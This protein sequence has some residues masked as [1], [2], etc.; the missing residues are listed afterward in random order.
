MASPFVEDP[1]ELGVQIVRGSLRKARVFRDQQNTVAFLD[2]FLYERYKF[3]SEGM[4]YLCQPLEPWALCCQCD[5]SEL[6]TYSP[7]D[8]THC[9]ALLCY[10][11]YFCKGLGQTPLSNPSIKGQPSLL[12]RAS[13][14]AGVYS[15]VGGHFSCLHHFIFFSCL[16]QAMS[17]PFHYALVYWS[18]PKTET[19]W[20]TKALYL[21][22]L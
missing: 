3:S 16:L 19:D 9:L 13:S 15:C 22:Y 6:C 18:H 21:L 2:N 11:T 4:T 14:S 12:Q 7:A 10:L 20:S 5:T 1:V 17:K 8:C